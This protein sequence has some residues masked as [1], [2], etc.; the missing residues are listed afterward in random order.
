MF[1]DPWNWKE[2]FMVFANF[3]LEDFPNFTGLAAEL[4][5]WYNFWDEIN[6]KN[7]LLGSISATL[8]RVDALAFP[9]KYLALKLLR[10]LP[11]TTR[12]CEKSFSSPRSIKTWDRS[13][14]T[15]GKLSR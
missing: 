4:D 7:D 10:T 1:R 9:N 13:T 3:Y 2:K 12:E 8:K 11:I 14:M 15:N 5:L 6:Y